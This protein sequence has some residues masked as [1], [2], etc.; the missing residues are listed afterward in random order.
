MVSRRWRQLP[1]FDI[2]CMHINQSVCSV[3]VGENLFQRLIVPYR[4]QRRQSL[5]LVLITKPRDIA[6]IHL[7]GLLQFLVLAEHVFVGEIEDVIGVDI[8]LN[9]VEFV[10]LDA[11]V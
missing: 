7:L 11:L 1:N 3:A 8:Q 2:Y 6:E 5:Q 10:D 9:L 4:Q